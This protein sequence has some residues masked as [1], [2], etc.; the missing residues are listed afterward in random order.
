MSFH[1]RYSYCKKL[2][3]ILVPKVILGNFILNFG[4]APSRGG[5]FMD[6]PYVLTSEEFQNDALNKYTPVIASAKN[7]LNIEELDAI[8]HRAKEQDQVYRAIHRVLSRK[9]VYGY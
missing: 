4:R 9:Y 2:L 6:F 3:N 7:G 5:T 8:K 1:L